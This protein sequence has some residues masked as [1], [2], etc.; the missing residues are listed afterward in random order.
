MNC[1]YFD[2]MTDS[3]SLYTCIEYDRY[4]YLSLISNNWQKNHVSIKNGMKNTG[5]YAILSRAMTQHRDIKYFKTIFDL[6]DKLDVT[7]TKHDFTKALLWTGRMPK[8][9]EPMI[10]EKFDQYFK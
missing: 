7:P 3:R 2:G 5:Q 8:D 6:C 9:C 10:R 4:N 1:S